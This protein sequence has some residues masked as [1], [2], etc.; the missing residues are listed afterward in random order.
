MK[1]FLIFGG[2][3]LSV[4]GFLFW[5]LFT[6]S[7]NDFLKPYIERV[8][9]NKL[10]KS[11]VLET[12]TL[13]TSFIDT[14]MTINKNSKVIINGTFEILK[15]SFDLDYEIDSKDLNTPF[16]NIKGILVLKGK[17][18]GNRDAFS[19]KG[20]GDA[21]RSR[22][23]FIANISN[24]K[25]KD[26]FID[27]K[28]LK[29]EDVLTFVKKP[30]YSRGMFDIEADIKSLE[31]GSYKGVMS[32]FIHYGNLNNDLIQRDFGV[33][34]G[35]AVVY[36]GKIS[37]N[38]E[39]SKL[40]VKSDIFSNLLQLE[41]KDTQFDLKSKE[42][43]S[44]YKL[45]VPKLEALKS[46]I[47]ISLI[48]NIVL[49]GNIKK[50]KNDLA[51]E[52]NSKWLGGDLRAILFNNTLKADFK[53]INLYEITN[54]LN[55][56]RYSSGLAS[57]SLD[58]L[59]IREESRDGKVELHVE[60]A[61]VDKK[62]MKEMF[63]LEVPENLKYKI[64][65]LADIKKDK[66]IIDS[67][68]NSDVLSLNLPQSMY[69]IKKASLGG[70]YLLHVE[71]LRKLEFI[72][73]RAMHGS[74]DVDGEFNLNENSIGIDGKSDF[75]DAKTLLQIRYFTQEFLTHSQL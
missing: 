36:K 61:I 8:M 9:T 75:L 7:G 65:S 59:D 66:V 67:T 34:L 14:E 47:G 50:D 42:L 28:G 60:D 54:M 26:I 55:K 52:A 17:I 51:I 57:I 56:P 38:I 27:A 37:S 58:M 29:V 18:L 73:K 3:L 2:I 24:E 63:K 40:H 72:T 25:L 23:K 31:D 5:I 4:I 13:K 71:D 41:T 22:V 44:D 1:F 11:V 32:A 68:L 10:G 33:K 74:V 19:I 30:L 70:K 15:N 64:S 53:N 12:F 62:T 16:V 20:E 45:S 46:I 69:E 39:G 35:Q 6:F 49:E 43:Y 21:F 48:G